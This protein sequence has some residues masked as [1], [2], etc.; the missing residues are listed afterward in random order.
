M[1]A[2]LLNESA[3]T[4]IANSQLLLKSYAPPQNVK[5]AFLFGR[6]VFKM[7]NFRAMMRSRSQYALAIGLTDISARVALFRQFNNG[8]QKPFA[9]FDF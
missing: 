3:V 9:S 4:F 6:A 5:E 8:W 1:T 2:A 7:E